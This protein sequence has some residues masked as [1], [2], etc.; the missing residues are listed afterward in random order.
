MG[1]GFRVPPRRE[2]TDRRCLCVVFFSANFACAAGC[3]D[4]MGAGGLDT[5]CAGRLGKTG[6]RIGPYVMHME[7]VKP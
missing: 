3:L 4:T 6:A 7:I 5:T 2:A 1:L